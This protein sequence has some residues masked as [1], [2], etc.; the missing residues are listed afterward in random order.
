MIA[1]ARREDRRAKLRHD[2]AIRPRVNPGLGAS[3]VTNAFPHESVVRDHLC[4]APF[5]R[6]PR[7]LR[8]RHLSYMRVVQL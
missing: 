6:D 7:C 2:P 8:A 3:A 1:A 5:G 4:A